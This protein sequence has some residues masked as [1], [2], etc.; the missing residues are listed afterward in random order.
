MITRHEKI[1][2]FGFPRAGGGMVAPGFGPEV[3][4]DALYGSDQ[5]RGTAG[6]P[7]ATMAKAFAY[8]Q[9]LQDDSQGQA[10]DARIYLRGPIFENL[11]APD[12]I[13]GVQ[14]IGI[15][16]PHHGSTSNESEGTAPAWRTAAGVSTEPLLV[17]TTQG[18]GFHNILFAPGS[19][20]S[21]IELQSD[22]G[23]SPEK[24]V[25]GT[26]ISGCRFAQG[27]WAINDNGGSGYVSVIGNHFDGQTTAS[28]EGT[29]TANALPLQWR[30]MGNYFGGASASH[31]IAAAS[32]WEIKDNSFGTVA[33]TAKYIDLNNGANNVVTKN[34][35]GGVY[36]TDD[37]RAGTSD[38]W[39]GNWVTVIST[40]APNGFTILA[41]AAP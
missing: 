24:T 12:D 37:Y 27:K 9:A 28:I 33:S 25:S 17:L 16:N 29:S 39:L 32:K 30:V 31:I 41:P 38:L 8:L 14:I 19:A 34:T 2:V 36:N 1:A 10:D 35:L 13:V 11:T 7:F 4:V 40:Q 23:A 6:R 5:D 22:G 18:W 3:Y 21:A 15:G 26:V 20:D